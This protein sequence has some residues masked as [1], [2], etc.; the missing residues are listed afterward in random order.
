MERKHEWMSRRQVCHE[1]F[2][3]ICF[4]CPLLRLAFID[5]SP[6]FPPQPSFNFFSTFLQTFCVSPQGFFH[7]P[8]KTANM[9]MEIHLFTDCCVKS[10]QKQTVSK[11]T[12][13]ML[14][15][16]NMLETFPQ[17]MLLS[18]NNKSCLP[19]LYIRDKCVVKWNNSWLH[20]LLNQEKMCCQNICWFQT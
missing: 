13:I 20:S 1:L 17:L 7:A 16:F 19:R 18:I 9:R 10:S 2:A 14:L 11:R 6:R 3:T 8:L 12:R 4:H 15:T 5:T